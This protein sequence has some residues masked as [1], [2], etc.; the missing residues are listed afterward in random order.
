[1]RV[2]QGTWRSPC[3]GPQLRDVNPKAEKKFC[4]GLCGR[5]ELQA[6]KKVGRDEIVFLVRQ[7]KDGVYVAH[8]R[9]YSIFTQADGIQELEENIKEAVLCHFEEAEGPVRIRIV[10]TGGEIQSLS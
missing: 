4:V 2:P 5:I 3:E 9:G 8:A 10:R 7:E 1:M 6:M